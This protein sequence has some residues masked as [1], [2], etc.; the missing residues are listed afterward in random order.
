MAGETQEGQEAGEDLTGFG[1]S[2]KN[3]DLIMR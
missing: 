1:K 2:Y 3:H